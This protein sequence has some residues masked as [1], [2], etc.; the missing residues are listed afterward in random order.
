MLING[1]NNESPTTLS[2]LTANS[3]KG[4]RKKKWKGSGKFQ[5]EKKAYLKSSQFF[6][7]QK[8]KVK[9]LRMHFP[10]IASLNRSLKFTIPKNQDVNASKTSWIFIFFFAPTFCPSFFFN[11]R[12]LYFIFY[13][14]LKLSPPL[15]LPLTRT[16]YLLPNFIS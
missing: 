2:E 6:K 15:P 3:W 7:F 9:F 14:S 8:G 11:S 1:S 4:P 5:E 16:L 12:F 10:G 13:I